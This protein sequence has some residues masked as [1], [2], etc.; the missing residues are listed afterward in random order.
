MT[1]A[2]TETEAF[3]IGELEKRSLQYD[4]RR[5]F[6]HVVC[7][8]HPNSGT[9]LK[10]GFSRKT[11]GMHCWVCEKKGHW[12]E[13]AELKQL[14]SFRVNDPRLQDFKALARQFDELLHEKHVESPDWLERWHGRW[15]NLDGPFLRSIPSYMWFDEASGAKRILWPVYMDDQFK[16]C[17]AAR[18]HHDTW[19][20]TRNLA[21][22]NA[23]RILWPFDHPL[24]RDSRSIVLVEGQFDALRLLSQNIPAVSIMG[25]GNWSVHKLNRLAARGV[26]RIVIAM[27]GDVPGELAADEIRAA[28]QNRFDVRTFPLPDP[29][30]EERA[31]G[32]DALD[33]GNC[34][35]RYVRLIGRLAMSYHA[36]KSRTA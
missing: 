1:E 27:D 21:G 15:R 10:L 34:C 12:N 6:I 11:G 8:F 19:P 4:V 36:S 29:T 16:G 30:P 9:K 33:P 23:A 5:D 2:S 20:K 31:C 22:I 13:Y 17:M 28:A 32:I 26:E 14:E 3:I 25:T 24:V 7:P 18:L 35:E